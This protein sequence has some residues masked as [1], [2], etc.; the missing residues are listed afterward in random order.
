LTGQVTTAEPVVTPAVG[1]ERFHVLAYDFGVKSRAIRLL[2]E[3][4]CRVTTMPASTT[5]EEMLDRDFDGLFVSNGPGDPEAID[6][7]V[8]AIR[9]VAE[10]GIPVFGICLGH[11]L[12]ARAFG[13]STFKMLYGH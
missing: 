8:H 1:T 10:L 12:L 11:Q 2:A 4:G 13:G 6:H 9:K 5:A 3:R 7:A